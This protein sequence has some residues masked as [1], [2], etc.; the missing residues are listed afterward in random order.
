MVY[1]VDT[2][3][4]LPRSAR[5]IPITA[6]FE[7]DNIDLHDLDGI[8]MANSLH[9]IKDKTALLKKLRT[10][11]QPQAPMII[12]EYDTDQP[13][14]TWVPYPLSFKSLTS[15]FTN[16]G[17]PHIQKLGERPSAYGRANIYAAIAFSA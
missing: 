1:G 5:I 2:R 15:L 13:V 12:V 14:S 3:P 8:L 9:Y 16:A 4:T 17:Y 7:K 6:D 11:L 10:Y